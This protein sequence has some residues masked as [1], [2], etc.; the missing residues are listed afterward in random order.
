MNYCA[1]SGALVHRRAAA[2]TA[3]L[4]ACHGHTLT[5]PHAPVRQRWLHESVARQCKRTTTL[6]TDIGRYEERTAS[7]RETRHSVHSADCGRLKE[8]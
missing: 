6:G 8:T 3:M 7:E 5:R 4:V 1:M 2:S